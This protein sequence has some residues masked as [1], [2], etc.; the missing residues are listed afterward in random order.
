MF[1]NLVINVVKF[2]HSCSKI[3]SL[4]LDPTVVTHH[5]PQQHLPSPTTTT[6]PAT[7]T[8]GTTYLTPGWVGG[9]W[10]ATAGARAHR[11]GKN[12]HKTS[13]RTLVCNNSWSRN[14]VIY[15]NTFGREIWSDHIRNLVI[16][17]QKFGQTIWSNIVVNLVIDDP[18]FGHQ[19]YTIWSLMLQKLLI[20]GIQFGHV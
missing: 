2:G 9:L 1:Q 15:C 11:L 19:C 3:W 20:N 10:L 14:V 16:S 13:G 7:I 4:L 5:L 12:I 6:Y 8:P 18:K 17:R